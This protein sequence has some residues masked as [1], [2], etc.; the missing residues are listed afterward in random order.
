LLAVLQ[1]EK[2]PCHCCPKS[3]ACVL[4]Q[5]LLVPSAVVLHVQA[6]LLLL[7]VPLLLGGH[8]YALQVWCL[9]HQKGQIVQLHG[10]QH[11]LTWAVLTL[12]CWKTS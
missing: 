10:Q 6:G 7:G 3:A 5:A 8:L 4:L 9:H 1:Q 2:D 12:Q 11:V